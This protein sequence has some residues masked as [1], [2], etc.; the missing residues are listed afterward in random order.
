MKEERNVCTTKYDGD[1]DTEC[2]ALCDAMNSVPGI[3]TTSS[4]CGHGEREYR[5]WFHADN[6]EALPPL[7]YWFA[8]CHCGYYGWKA[9]VSTDCGCSPAHF[10][11]EGPTGAAAYKEAKEIA[12]L[13]AKDNAPRLA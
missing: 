9:I 13:I 4:C 5:V 3:R 6:L 11:V 1:I 10:Y 12:R 2:V 8:G 7:I